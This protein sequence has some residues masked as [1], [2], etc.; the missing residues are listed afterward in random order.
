MSTVAGAL[1]DTSAGLF[2]RCRFA[3]RTPGVSVTCDG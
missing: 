2:P 3:S 1:Q